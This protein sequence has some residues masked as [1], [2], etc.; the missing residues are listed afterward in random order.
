MPRGSGI[1]RVVLL[2]TDF[3]RGGT[4]LRLLRLALGL[5]AAGVE[6][7][8][9]CLAGPG[10]VGA[11]LEQAGV[12]TFA[13]GAT[14]ILSFG[15]LGRLES[16][17]RRLRP[18]L[19]HSTLTHANV[20]ARLVGRRLGVPVVGSTATI[21]VERLW[22]VWAERLTG[23]IDAGHVVAS[24]V[25]AEHVE[26]TFRIRRERIH[27]VPPSVDPPPPRH[28]AVERARLGLREDEFVVLW[29]GRL[30]PVKRVDVLLDA[31][32]ILSPEPFRL[33]LA[34][35]GPQRGRIERR[36]ASGGL[37]ERVHLLGWCDDLD[38]A[39][40]ASDAAACVSRTEGMP[41]AV[42]EAMAAGLAVLGGDIPALRELCGD[43]TRMLLVDGGD[44]RAVAAGLRRLRD[45]AGLRTSLAQAALEWALRAL[46]PRAT[47]R[48]A[49]GVY[50][51]IA[52]S[53]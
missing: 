1:V 6:V 43:G 37:R 48:A 41:N 47:V 19:I 31:A 7:V 12:K 34:G 5:R 33:L 36:I 23:G 51:R 22:H 46:D 15:A 30:D 38:A 4:P 25:L 16:H 18:D 8:A 20:A 45:D 32:E 14:S 49:L 29:A 3:Q 52:S 2:A 28:R 26:R 42:L 40:A 24:R 50:E 53:R 27:V 35:D 9:G 44:A 11:R 39:R 17:L 10:P 13:C 21:E